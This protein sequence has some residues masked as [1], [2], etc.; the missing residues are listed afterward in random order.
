MTAPAKLEADETSVVVDS[1]QL[2]DALNKPVDVIVRKVLA[3]LYSSGPAKAVRDVHAA[4]VGLADS[5]RPAGEILRRL[6]KLK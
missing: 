5:A 2:Q 6:G 4:R 3:E 1:R